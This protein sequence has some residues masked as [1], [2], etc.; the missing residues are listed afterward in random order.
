MLV[1]I[2]AVKVFK[3][4]YFELLISSD[5]VFYH[6]DRVSVR[7]Y[8]PF[9]QELRNSLRV[10]LIVFNCVVYNRSASRYIYM[11]LIPDLVLIL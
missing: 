6:R 8:V 9:L 10:V 4:P 2:M 11:S 3:L 5:I 1:R 7:S